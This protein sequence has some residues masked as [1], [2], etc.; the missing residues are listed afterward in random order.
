MK[1][2]GFCLFL[3]KYSLFFVRITIFKPLLAYTELM[4]R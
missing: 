4:F 2:N 1:N 3:V